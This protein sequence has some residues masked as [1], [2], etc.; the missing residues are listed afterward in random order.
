MTGSPLS[1]WG[2]STP[3]MDETFRADRIVMA[4][5]R[6]EAGLAMSLGDAGIAPT[7]EV[8]AV[9]AACDVQVGDAEGLLATT[10]ETGTPMLAVVEL[11]Q[12]RLAS[13]EERRWVHYGST[14]QDAIDTAY[15]LLTKDA[16]AILESGLSEVAGK[17]RTLVV[18]HRDQLQ[19]GRTFLQNAIPTT[20]GLRVAGWLD[21]ILT[22]LER[23][24]ETREGLAVQLGGPVGNLSTFGDDG[25]AVVA[26]LA[27]RLDLVAPDV[28]WHTDRTRV[29]DVVNTVDD[30]VVSLA[31]VASDLALLAQSGVGEVTTRAGESSSMPHK[32]NPIDAV[33]ALAAADVCH[34]A[35]AMMRIGRPHELDRS[36]GSWQAEWVA[37]PLLFSAAAAVVAATTTL[38]EGLE[39][40][41]SAMEWRAGEAAPPN[42]A[43]IDTVLH[44]YSRVVGD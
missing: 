9:A 8:E 18:E 4:M 5:L 11:V 23:L 39:V 12:A 27:R 40:N 19:M 36:L 32:K 20:F 15:V 43:M 22:H 38:V 28:P 21:P 42:T 1:I 34:G 44:R 37:I 16:L 29:R 7:A 3:A 41:S 14:T 2:F 25:S 33:R 13:D 10:W 24:G 30:A 17:M 26:A 35:A 31:K 6:F